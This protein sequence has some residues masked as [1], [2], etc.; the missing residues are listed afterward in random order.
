MKKVLYNEKVWIV[1]PQEGYCLALRGDTSG[2]MASELIIP[3]DSDLIDKVIEVISTKK[4]IYIPDYDVEQ[5]KLDLDEFKQYII[6]Q[7][8]ILLEKYLENNPIKIGDEFY[9]V[10]KSSQANLLSMIKTGEMAVE[11]GVDFIPTWA[12]IGKVQREYSLQ[13][14]KKIFIEIQSYVHKLVL[15]Q[16]MKEQEILA[17]TS[18][19]DLL[20]LDM[21]YH[22]EI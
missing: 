19:E 22:I 13:D 15:Q 11:I 7:T 3:K 14:L 1:S 18:K 20:D 21:N 4:D 17:I 9:S 6:Q 12:P 16:Q 5:K 8:K 10:S 2:R